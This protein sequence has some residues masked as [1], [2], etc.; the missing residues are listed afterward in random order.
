[1]DCQ[2]MWDQIVNELENRLSRMYLKP[3]IEVTCKTSMQSLLEV[4]SGFGA[5][6]N[7]S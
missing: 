4:V 3:T 5:Q 2:F 1:M 7:L 6:T